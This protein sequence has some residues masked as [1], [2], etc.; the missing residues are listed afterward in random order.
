MKKWTLFL[1]SATSLCFGNEN[2]E[3][4]LSPE[5]I[6]GKIE[7]VAEK[8]T[9]EYAGEPLTLILV[10][11]GAVCIGTDLLRKLPPT[12]TL[13]Y[14]KA[15]S[16]GQ[17]GVQRGALTID[18]LDRLALEGKH[19]LLVDD[20]FDSGATMEAIASELQKKN[21]KS[22]KSLTL[23]MKNVPH[24]TEYRPDYVLFEIED[25]FVVGY[26]LDLKEEY[27]GLPGVYA[28]KRP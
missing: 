20:I 10:M 3:L 25:R 19:L 18:G 16:Y 23:L 15:S 4:L 27:R 6:A 28:F 12:T 5:E 17:N 22:L 21:P 1:L 14:I 13:E 11:K 2:L 24:A 9:A 26:G 7:Q 8:L